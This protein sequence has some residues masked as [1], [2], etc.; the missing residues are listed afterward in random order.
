MYFTRANWMSNFTIYR[1]D[2]VPLEVLTK[3]ATL[4]SE[5]Y[6]VWA[7]TAPPNLVGKRVRMNAERLKQ[8]YLWNSEQCHLVTASSP[9][10]DIYGHVFFVKFPFLD[11]IASWITQLVVHSAHRSKGIATQLCSLV[12]Q[13][14]NVAWGLITSHPYAV[15]ALEHAT[16]KKCD[17]VVIALHAAALVDASGVPYVQGKHLRSSADESVIETDFHVDHTEVDALV[18]QIPAWRLG[19][20]N[21][22]DEYFAFTFKTQ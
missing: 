15:R 10:G 14:D 22:G 19:K 18:A 7:P 4:F 11:G 20:L 5:N 1:A 2:Q 9:N 13:R 8:Q 17:P 12:W 6:G 16:G 21:V 3:C